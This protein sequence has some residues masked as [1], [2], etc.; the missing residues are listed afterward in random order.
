M[1]ISPTAKTPGMLVSKRAVST[2]ICFLSS[3]RP[4]SAI[5]PSFGCKPE[6]NEQV[7]SRNAASDAVGAGDLNFGHLAVFFRKA[8]NLTDFKLH[9]PV[10]AKLFHLANRGRRS[11]EAFSAVD[12]YNAFGLADEV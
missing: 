4:Q 6:E 5:G 10:V 11:S 12:Q 2:T 9:F 7:F 1:L 8:G 3:V